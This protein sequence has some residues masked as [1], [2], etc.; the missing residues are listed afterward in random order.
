MQSLV[1]KESHHLLCLKA[2]RQF[3]LKPF[4]LMSEISFIG[5]YIFHDVRFYYKI[6]EEQWIDQIN[7][8]IQL[9]IPPFFS[10]KKRNIHDCI[11]IIRYFSNL[12]PISL[13]YISQFWQFRV[14]FA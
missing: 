9:N 2:A 8:Q 13:N 10:V 14:N 11:P 4:R 5:F 3:D 1:V 12:M 7:R 6:N